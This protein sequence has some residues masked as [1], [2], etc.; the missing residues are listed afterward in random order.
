M[1]STDTSLTPNTARS[2]PP[3]STPGPP[4]EVWFWCIL[5]KA[6]K[7]RGEH[8]TLTDHVQYEGWQNIWTRRPP[9]PGRYRIEFRDARRAIVRVEYV[10]VPDPRSGAVPY[11]THGRIRCPQRKIPPASPAWEAKTPFPAAPSNRSTPTRLTQP[12]RSTTATSA[13]TYP[14]LRPPGAAPAG[15]LWRLRRNHAW[16]PFDQRQAIPENY[17]RLW[18][19]PD[20]VILVYSATGIWPGY[21]LGNLQ[22]GLP[23]LVP[24][25]A[26][27]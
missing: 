18:L 7:G 21:T 2:R 13:T 14:P 3:R 19:P 5:P 26:R 25:N 11:F 8:R 4:A 1:A 15:M 10:N 6:K 17:H 9:A 27:S 20:Q 12:R 23:C 24:Q 16:E 22:G